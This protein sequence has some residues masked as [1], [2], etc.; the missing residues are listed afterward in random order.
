MRRSR[1]PALLTLLLTASL[2]LTACG[3]SSDELVVYSGRGQDLIGP[4]LE[5]FNEE[6]G[7]PIAVRY[8]DSSDLALLLDEEGDAT[9]ADVV[10]TQNPG[11]VAFLSERGRLATLDDDLLALVEPRF[12]SSTGTW[13][14]LSGRQ[15]VFV[16]NQD[17]IGED[18][19]PESVFDLVEPEW[20]GRFAVAPPNG[21]FQDF[22][23]LMRLEVGDDATRDWLEGIVA[24]DVRTYPNNNSIVDAVARGEVEFGL[25][26]H[27]YNYRFLEEDPSL[28]SRN[29]VPEGDVGS[30]VIVSTA[31]VVS[32]TDQ[33]DAAEQLLRFLLSEESQTYFT[34]ET[35]EYPLVAGVAASPELPS[36][37][38]QELP[39]VDFDALGDE[40]RSTV[41]LID[42]SGLRN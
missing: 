41:E 11:A 35:F 10:I 4:L 33:P 32:G 21:S 14:G 39:V 25:V 6:T 5:R 31:S 2:A 28:P 16:Y 15:R 3:G 42:A 30:M 1:R 40:L 20:Q 24:N 9:D 37:A 19:L 7:I 23:S 38:D 34:T 36:L 18:E 12:E 29:H 22:V 17:L 8:G 13:V 27:Y 26:N